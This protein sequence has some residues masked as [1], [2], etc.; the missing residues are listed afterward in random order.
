[1]SL[2]YTTLRSSTVP[3]GEDV[4]RKNL[5]ILVS[6]ITFIQRYTGD[7]HFVFY[8]ISNP[9]HSQRHDV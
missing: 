7:N 8:V 3:I 9:R 5:K 1:M 4:L 6:T 2:M